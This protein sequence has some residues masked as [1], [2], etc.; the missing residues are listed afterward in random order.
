MTFS[1]SGSAHASHVDGVHNLA[2]PYGVPVLV[3]ALARKEHLIALGVPPLLATMMRVETVGSSHPVRHENALLATGLWRCRSASVI[4]GAIGCLETK[5]LE[6]TGYPM[7]RS[8]A[9]P[10]RRRHQAHLAALAMRGDSRAAAKGLGI[11]TLD[12]HLLRAR[13]RWLAEEECIDLESVCDLPDDT[14]TVLWDAHGL[15][16]R[17]DP[18]DLEE[19]R[20]VVRRAELRGAIERQRKGAR[21]LNMPAVRLPPP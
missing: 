6:Q 9:P 8:V 16:L 14:L 20:A 12:A 7:K 5:I 10:G 2:G 19:A 18:S 1:S 11:P 17:V 4:A 3:W 15:D 13:M 21:R